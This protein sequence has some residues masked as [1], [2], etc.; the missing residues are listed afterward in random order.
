MVGML[1]SYE[2]RAD[3]IFAALLIALFPIRDCSEASIDIDAELQ[4][5]V[6]FKIMGENCL[7]K[8]K[9]NDFNFDSFI[10][11]CAAQPRPIQS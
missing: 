9:K 11:C 10:F 3:S 1:I 5:P 4:N 8:Q 6:L 2:N 7:W